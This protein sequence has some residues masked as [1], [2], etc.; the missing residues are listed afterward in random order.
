M[1]RSELF[2]NA[3]I[4]PLDF[5][6]L[7]LAG[8]AAYYL[9][10]SP[11][12]QGFRPATFTIDLPFIT[13][14]RLVVAVAMIIILIFAAQ[15][16][17]AMRIRRRVSEEITKIFTGIS[18]G[19]MLV[20]VYIFLSA[21]LFQSRFILLAAYIFAVIFVASGR[22]FVRKV[23][24]LMLDW[25]YGIYRVVLVGNGPYGEKLAGILRSSPRLG[26]RVV[27]EFNFVSRP[28]LEEI[29]RQKAIDEIIQT[30]PSLPQ[31]DNLVLM[32]FCDEH[33]IDYKYVPNLYETLATNVSFRQLGGVPIVEL[34]RTPLEG[35]GRINKKIM[36]LIGSVLGLIFLSPLFGVVALLIT[37]DS[38][39]KVFYRQARVGKN[40]QLFKIYKFRTMRQEFCVGEEYGGKKA[41]EYYAS[42]RQVANER[43][44]PLFKLKGD[45]RITGIGKW[46]RRWRI[47]EL[48]QL[49]NV[50]RGEMSL[51]GPRPHLPEEVSRY[52]KHH[53]KLFTIKPGMSGMAQVN[54]SSSL[55]FNEEANFDIGYIE[56]WSLKL[57]IILLLKTLRILLTDKNAV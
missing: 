20:I 57:D 37:Y 6:M 22:F 50:L 15:G 46:L 44:G 54:G 41:A 33:K 17:Y 16:L 53:R 28:Q 52:E 55:S 10:V 43:G 49:F 47:D 51:I 36:D 14:L 48:P 38:P 3:A 30:E 1:K 23:Q 26:Y 39:G 56:H 11:W 13:Y 25:S 27:G 21:E 7:V 4:L 45:P 35:W 31:E 5:L 12:V 19:M 18:Q 2:F 32:D 24:H 29:H 8:I 9:R 42:L 40:K 34:M